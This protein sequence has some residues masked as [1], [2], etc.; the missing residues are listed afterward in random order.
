M[1]SENLKRIKPFGLSKKEKNIFFSKEIKNLTKYHYQNSKDYRKL[2]TFFDYRLDN[3]DLKNMPFLPARLFKEL[4]LYSVEKNK[5]FK[6]LMS[7]A[8]LSTTP[9]S[10]NSFFKSL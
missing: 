2:L 7:S 4:S 10:P 3:N 9:S 8:A 1:K 5:I 6:T